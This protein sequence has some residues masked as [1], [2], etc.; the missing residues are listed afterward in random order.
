VLLADSRRIPEQRPEM[1][2]KKYKFYWVQGVADP[3]QLEKA[4]GTDVD[5]PAAT[6]FARIREFPRLL[7]DRE[8][9]DVLFFVALQMTRVPRFRK[10]VDY[11]YASEGLRFFAEKVSSA[12]VSRDAALR[13]QPGVTKKKIIAMVRSGELQITP[14]QNSYLRSMLESTQAIIP[15]LERRE[16]SVR[17][18][19]IGAPDLI[20]SDLPVKSI[21]RL[22]TE[23]EITTGRLSWP[24]AEV[25]IAISSH[26]ALV[27]ARRRAVVE[28]LTVSEIAGF[29]FATAGGA[30][31]L[32]SREPVVV[33][34]ADSAHLSSGTTLPF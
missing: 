19:P 7:T 15:W 1:V 33:G 16:W 9:S 32:Y 11:V 6:V 4:L 27:G 23:W 28:P 30:T 21:R 5:G 3:A 8:L 13:G 17:T 26:I 25:M 12:E 2:A 20:S 29:N 10:L 18:V 31:E 24:D 22:G 14:R 34:V